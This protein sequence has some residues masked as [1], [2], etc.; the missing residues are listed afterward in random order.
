M[1][2]VWEVTFITEDNYYETVQLDAEDEKELNELIDSLKEELELKEV[3]EINEVGEVRY[4]VYLIGYKDNK[5]TDYERFAGD[6]HSKEKAIDKFEEI[7]REAEDNSDKFFD[8]TEDVDSWLLQVEEVECTDDCDGCV[9][10][11]KEYMITK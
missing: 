4:M 8:G 5:V 9:D 7:V 1:L 11:I 3:V 2:K 6:F 10:F